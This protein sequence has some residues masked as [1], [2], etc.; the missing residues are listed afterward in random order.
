MHQPTWRYPVDLTGAL[1]KARRFA[2]GHQKQIDT[3]LDK[4]ARLAK[5]HT[6]NAGDKVIDAATR[7][8]TEE[9]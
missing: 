9:L 7:K 8:A 5:E 6:P 2:A 4:A 1:G 3:A